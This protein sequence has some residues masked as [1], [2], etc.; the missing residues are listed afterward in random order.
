VFWAAPVTRNFSHPN[1][2]LTKEEPSVI[3]H[4]HKRRR[5]Y[6]KKNY[7]RIDFIGFTGVEFIFGRENKNQ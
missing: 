4:T 2:N 5:K 6:E 1:Y 3:I 7:R